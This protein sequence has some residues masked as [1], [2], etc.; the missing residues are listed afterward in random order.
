MRHGHQH[1]DYMYHYTISVTDAASEI[2]EKVRRKKKPWV[3]RDLHNIC[4]ERKDLKKQK[5]KNTGEQKRF[6]EGI[7]G[8]KEGLD[9]YSVRGD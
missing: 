5:Q 6:S 4:G 7:G 3:T 1:H 8:S 2:L 9:R